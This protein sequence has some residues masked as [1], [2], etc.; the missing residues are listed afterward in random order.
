MV[1]TCLLYGT[2]NWVNINILV[3]MISFT[4]VAIL[5]ALS[6]TFP[7]ATREKLKQAAT[8]E[9]SQA[10][11]SVIIILVLAAF[12]TT[13]CSMSSTISKS[14]TGQTLDPFQYS[15]YYVGNLST[16]TGL[17]L[18]TNLYSIS[19]SY[20]IEAQVL[21]S[22][23]S[24][25]NTAFSSAASVLGAAFGAAS[26]VVTIGIAPAISSLSSLFNLLSGLYL[27]VIAPLVTIVIGLLF[28]QFLA[29]PLLQYTAFTIVLPIAIAM[30]SLAFLGT[31]LRSASNTILAM[32]IAGYIVYPMM[33]AFNGYIVAW[34]FSSSNPSYQYIGSTYVVPNIPV[35]A[36]FSAGLPSYTGFF[37]SIFKSLFQSNLF[38][39]LLTSSFG[40]T[41]LIT[42][43]N[44]VSQ[45]Q[46]IINQTA[47]F[48][49]EGVVLFVMDIAVTLGF[50]IGL[51]RAL[52]SGIEGAGSFW[53][54]L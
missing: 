50:A 27:D 14:L 39:P 13:A 52:N 43:F 6:N 42:P 19:V 22:L 29:L 38:I 40:S 46:L 18:L 2:M 51:S 33:V 21:Q 5:F 41:G 32:A 45:A 10:F 3:I 35:S 11:I 53:G 12:A 34:T 8:S 23:G 26:K 4:V 25:L 31:P 48:L 15:E 30:R 17:N 37:G 54:G 28:I 16:N 7:E 47:Q 9:L 36:Y 49:F 24:L 44:I 20:A 1:N